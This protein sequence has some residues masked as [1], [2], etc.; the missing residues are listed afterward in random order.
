MNTD[1]MGEVQVLT[2]D[3]ET[4][5][6]SLTPY[7]KSY[8]W[9]LIHFLGETP[10]P[11]GCHQ[12][13]PAPFLASSLRE[14]EP[15]EP[16]RRRGAGVRATSGGRVGTVRTRRAPTPPRKNVRP[17]GLRSTSNL[18][19][20]CVRLRPPRSQPLAALGPA[21][22][23]CGPPEESCPRPWGS[24]AAQKLSPVPT[25]FSRQ[26]EHN[27]CRREHNHFDHI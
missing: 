19:A 8:T 15:R 11:V 3:A 14:P 26:S 4:A 21:E 24:E 10:A 5:A 6:A 13:L 7:P 20:A 25:C 22:P 2:V 23:P 1:S 9:Y 16:L 18:H 12:P 27:H 17:R